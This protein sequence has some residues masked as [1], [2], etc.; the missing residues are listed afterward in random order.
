VLN[1]ECVVQGH[2]LG[3]GARRLLKLAAL[4]VGSAQT[5]ECQGFAARVARLA[6]IMQGLLVEADGFLGA[7]QAGE[8]RAKPYQRIRRPRAAN[9]IEEDVALAQAAGRGQIISWQT[10]TSVSSLAFRRCR[11]VDQQPAARHA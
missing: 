3:E 7:A 4:P 8:R 1:A 2:R 9:F 6:V 10:L 5:G 11:M